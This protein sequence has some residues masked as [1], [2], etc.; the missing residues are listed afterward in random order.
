MGLVERARHL[1]ARVPAST[2]EE[3]SRSLIELTD[4]ARELDTTRRSARSRAEYRSGLVGRAGAELELWERRAAQ[5]V[6][7]SEEEAARAALRRK[8]DAEVRRQSL[9][10]EAELAEAALVEIESL[11]DEV[12]EAILRLR[13]SREPR[14]AEAASRPPQP[15]R[16]AEIEAELRRLREL[17]LTR[18]AGREKPKP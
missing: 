1:L 8:H 15:P 7:A 9:R 6:L 3:R 11:G 12:S 4:L 10:S 17:A 2:N 18:R 5:A 16:S 14:S 13:P